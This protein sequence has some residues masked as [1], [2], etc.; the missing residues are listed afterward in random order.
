[1]WGV[2]LTEKEMTSKLP[3]LR[4][5]RCKRMDLFDIGDGRTMLCNYCEWS[6]DVSLMIA[7]KQEPSVSVKK[8]EEKIKQLEE[9]TDL[10]NNTGQDQK[11]YQ[12]TVEKMKSLLPKK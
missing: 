4:C 8:I 7:E 9:E 3:L 2:L 5:P 1:V 11:M 12:F 10:P 6:G